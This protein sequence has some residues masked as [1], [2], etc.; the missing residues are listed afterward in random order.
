MFYGKDWVWGKDCSSGIS[1]MWPPSSLF[2]NAEDIM[3]ILWIL[4]QESIDLHVKVGWQINAW[5]YFLKVLT[6]IQIK[7]TPHWIPNCWI[8][9]EFILK[10]QAYNLTSF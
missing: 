7:T 2:E 4:F 3:R 9:S 8:G 5:N 1:K 6:V 10:F